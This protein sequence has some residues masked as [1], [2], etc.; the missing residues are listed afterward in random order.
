MPRAWVAEY[1][2]ACFADTLR[3]I[4]KV[5]V[6]QACTVGEEGLGQ[7]AFSPAIPLIFLAVTALGLL[8]WV[9]RGWPWLAVSAILFMA[10]TA[11]PTA[12]VGPFLTYPL[13]TLMTAAF[14]V[15]AVKFK[16][17]EKEW[18]ELVSYN[19]TSNTNLI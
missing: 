14:V 7:G 10:S 16:P 17:G 1:H 15:T 3:Y 11:I 5:P 19:M 12:L 9:R 2:T 13:D 8:L 6:G 18:Q 4:G